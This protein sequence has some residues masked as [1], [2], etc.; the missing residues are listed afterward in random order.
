MIMFV[1][2]ISLKPTKIENTLC[3]KNFNTK[4]SPKL[5]G[6]R[7]KQDT[8][9]VNSKIG[10]QS[11]ENRKKEQRM[12]SREQ[13][14][15][16][17]ELKHK[18][19]P[20]VGDEC[21]FS[22]IESPS[23][24]YVHI[25]DEETALIDSL[26][27]QTNEYFNGTVSTYD[28]KQMAYTDIGKF[29]FAFI[30]DYQG[31]FRAEVLDWNMNELED[32]LIQLVDYGN[33]RI[34]SCKNLRKMIKELCDI[35]ML[36]TRC[37]FPLMYPAGSTCSNKLIEWSEIAVEALISLTANGAEN[38]FKIVY[39]Q[40][41]TNSMAIDLISACEENEHNTLG[42]ILLDVGFAVQIFDD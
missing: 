6:N 32:V 12:R 20:R 28:N 39:A 27:E 26:T 18:M 4:N 29:C 33:K 37:H 23:E 24:F 42:Q 15:S 16:F 41:K 31:W 35:P 9:N 11:K 3:V 13:E 2:D 34:I 38:I 10:A 14:D 1:P 5:K 25:R 7:V 21:A 40:K 17:L 8:R 36:A 19:P 30:H 22:H